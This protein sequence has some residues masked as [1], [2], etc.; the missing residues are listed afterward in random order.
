MTTQTATTEN[1]RKSSD[2]IN[3]NEMQIDFDI[4]VKS[5]SNLM[6]SL[7]TLGEHES[8]EFRNELKAV[9]Q[10]TEPAL[11]ELLFLGNT[12][13]S[14]WDTTFDTRRNWNNP[15]DDGLIYKG[16][17]QIYKGVKQIVISLRDFSNDP[18]N[19]IPA[20]NKLVNDSKDAFLKFIAAVKNWSNI[21]AGL[22]NVLR[23][24]SASVKNYLQKEGFENFLNPKLIAGNSKSKLFNLAVAIITG[25]GFGNT[26]GTV[27]NPQSSQREIIQ[28]I[29][30]TTFGIV[31]GGALAALILPATASFATVVTIGVLTGIVA[32]FAWEYMV[33]KWFKE[34]GTDILSNI[35][36][37]VSENIP[38]LIEAVKTT[39]SP[40]GSTFKDIFSKINKDVVA[41]FVDEKT[42]EPIG[43]IENNKFDI[44][45][46][47]SKEEY[48]QLFREVIDAK[49]IT[50]LTVN[51][52]TFTI[53]D[54][55][56][57]AVIR[58]N[59]NNIAPESF[60]T[61]NI[62][63]HPGEKLQ[64]GN[65]KD[66]YTIKKHDTIA[67]IAKANGIKVKELVALN[68]WLVDKNRITF[69]QDKLIMPEGVSLAIDTHT[70]HEYGDEETRAAVAIAQNGSSSQNGSTHRLTSNI[71]HPLSVSGTSG[72]DYLADFDGGDDKFYGSLKGG[73]T[74]AGGKGNDTYYLRLSGKLDDTVIDS[75]GRNR[76]YVLD[77]QGNLVR[78]TGGT[79]DK[80]R[81]PAH[82]FI[83]DDGEFIYRADEN[84]TLTVVRTRDVLKAGSGDLKEG[85]AKLFPASSGGSRTSGGGGT[86][87]SGPSGSDAVP[88]VP[89]A[90]KA[91]IPN[92]KNGDFGIR[93]R[94]DP[95]EEDP[96]PEVPQSEG[97]A[98]ST[99]EGRNASSPIVIDLD[100]NGVQT[101]ALNSRIVRFDLDNNG[102][103]ERVGWTD[104]IDG[105]LVRDIDG[106]GRIGNGGEL[107]GN[108]TK[109]RNGQ[110][111]ANGFEALKEL[112]D[113]GDGKITRADKVWSE[114]R[115]WQDRNQ[116]AWSAKGEL[117]T[118]DELGIAEI[119]TA[120]EN[121]KRVDAAGNT[122]KQISSAAKQDGTRLSVADVWFAADLADTRQ[123]GSWT[124][125]EAV[126]RLPEIRG[127]GNVPDLRRAMAGNPELQRAVEDYLAAD[128]AGRKKLLAPLIF[129]WTGTDKIPAADRRGYMN[130]R[131]LAVL[132]ALTGEGFLQ[133]GTN[134]NPYEGAT[135]A[136][137]LEYN[138]FLQYVAAHL[139]AQTNPIFRKDYWDEEADNWSYH[140]P[141]ISRR[142]VQLKAENKSDEI[143]ELMETVNGLVMYD[144]NQRAAWH[145]QILSLIDSDREFGKILLGRFAGS[146]QG[147][148]LLGNSMRNLLVG[149]GGDDTLE[150][151]G[152]NDTLIGG[153]G[154]D[155]L[156]GGSGDDTYVFAKG[157]G[158][159]YVADSSGKQ[160]FRFDG[161]KANEV[162]FRRIGDDL[163]LFGYNGSDS[164]RIDNYF[165]SWS[166]AYRN[167]EFQFADKTIDK[168]DIAHYAN[169][170]NNLIQTMAVFGNGSSAGVGLT[171]TAVQPV[172]QP[173][174]ATSS[175]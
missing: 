128:K 106:N 119:D 135:A 108:H 29:L 127:F 123:T 19:I 54:A 159:D 169:A 5:I 76:I 155:K 24:G 100:G 166:D 44:F 70:N 12:L 39:G 63:I 96:Y 78:L 98:P 40:F 140:W 120:Y 55:A 150:G 32:D 142:L 37:K 2:W 74:F 16:G 38:V 68:P 129:Q 23:K 146:E 60:I 99:S 26:N 30:G 152:G 111:A 168:P 66:F 91:L 134:P 160:T 42:G 71:N 1:E 59:L 80:D 53:N 57:S 131:E 43:K 56:S 11:K 45:K 72:R 65:G 94:E 90:G 64:L 122:H 67:A 143:A 81:L 95:R 121:S 9:S 153:A 7:L 172:V 124:P 18:R 27:S 17:K 33:P 51:G 115:V 85:L 136:L 156:Y 133:W 144:A 109:L 113:N 112:D 141:T 47:V 15:R 83:S 145:K 130:A 148:Q 138:A 73:D 164:V 97:G 174:L 79:R 132:E 126:F 116:D 167:I 137:T 105:F 154:N 62:L 103:A 82:T 61:S 86:G 41:F 31:A 46:P 34:L 4:H 25:A 87:G 75:E 117:Y 165:C 151:E 125:S 104:G 48:E 92:Y 139:Q 161:L 35:Y 147:E 107:F 157:H 163:E 118:L 52:E 170:A 171:D 88:A 77:E 101:H 162:Q 13:L 114:L 69:H 3:W 110:K 14:I 173:L 49:E 8:E 84:N 58:N 28:N 6:Q 158:S 21:Q 36:D 175:V 89:E 50:E 10:R 22:S 93:L 149:L 102:F 20:I